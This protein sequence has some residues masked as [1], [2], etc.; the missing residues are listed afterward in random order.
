MPPL[1]QDPTRLLVEPPSLV[2][3]VWP[4]WLAVLVDPDRIDVGHTVDLQTQTAAL[5]AMNAV[6]RQFEGSQIGQLAH[7][8]GDPTEDMFQI[9]PLALQ[10]QL[11]ITLQCTSTV[12][13]HLDR[14]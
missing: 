5:V 13:G 9:N 1:V 3:T 2:Q 4:F 11:Q 6:H 12:V 10:P 14:P 8:T 7:R